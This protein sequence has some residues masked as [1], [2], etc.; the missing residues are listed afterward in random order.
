MRL[1]VCGVIFG[2]YMVHIFL[3]DPYTGSEFNTARL[4]SVLSGVDDIEYYVFTLISDWVRSDYISRIQEIFDEDQI[5]FYVCGS[6]D[7]LNSFI[8]AVSDLSQ[9]EIAYIPASSN[10]SFLQI[11]GEK[12]SYFTDFD[13]MIHGNAVP[14]DYIETNHGRA[15][16]IVSL[17]YTLGFYSGSFLSRHK[18]IDLLFSRAVFLLSR[19]LGATR[20]GAQIIA[21]THHVDGNVSSIYFGNGCSQGGNLFFEEE[22]VIIDG[23]GTVG[24]RKSEGLVKSLRYYIHL[25]N[26]DFAEL[27]K[28]TNSFLATSMKVAVKRDKKITGYL[29]GIPAAEDSQWEIRMVREG[30][31][32]VLPRGVIL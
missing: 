21:D 30:L 25:R 7:T 27:K 32:F 3:L 9:V 31:R 18:S 15:M 2:G 16:N 24:Y 13:R 17:G 26:K 19:M 29:D 22:P 1:I 5:R 4:R 10:D 28:D 11:F 12:Y 23:R 14:I 8:N 6:S 20:F